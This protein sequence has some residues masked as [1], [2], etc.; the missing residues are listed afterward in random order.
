MSYA[1]RRWIS[2]F[3]VAFICLTWLPYLFAFAMTPPRMSYMW[4]LGNPDDQNVHLMWARQ[5]ADGA[6]TFKDLYTTEKHS[7]KFFHL[8]MLLLGLLHAVTE[9]PLH[10][11]YQVARTVAIALF[12]VGAYWLAIYHFD[13]VP[14]RRSFI[15]F[16]GFS[17]GFGWLAWLLRDW[18]GCDVPSFADVSKGLVMPEAITFL[19]MLV[20]P[21]TAVGV[22]LQACLMASIASFIIN[23]RWR[24]VLLASLISLILGNAHSYAALTVFIVILIWYP[25]NILWTM[26]LQRSQSLSSL[27][28]ESC[29][30]ISLESKI[31][32][33]HLA[34]VTAVCLCSLIGM[35]PQVFAFR[36]DIAFREKA[37][38]QTLTPPPMILLGTYGLLVPLS[39]IG[40]ALGIRNKWRMLAMPLAWVIG[41][42]IAI[43]LP[44][45][46][47]RKLIEGFHIP[48][49]MLA[50]YA[51]AEAPLKSRWRIS[52]KAVYGAV[53]VLTLLM[54]PS[55]GAYIG[56]N[57]YWLL[58]N[59][60]LAERL[61]QPPYYLTQNQLRLIS[62][63]RENALQDDAIIC[64]PMLGNYIPPI[65]GRT[66][67]IG[68]WA[69]TLH[70]TKK[71][72]TLV[73][74]Y[75]WANAPS[76]LAMWLTLT[77][78]HNVRFVLLTDFERAI[79]GGKTALPPFC[80]LVFKAGDD[81]AY[82]IDLTALAKLAVELD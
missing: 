50:A 22:A 45:S 25:L 26:L 54:F 42:L 9:L 76:Q 75:R 71:L 41:T 23:G 39:I 66:V 78:V 81:E 12:F 34:A 44:V 33:S 27:D 19:T 1:E 16:L 67:F 8:P 57:T 4:L 13:H 56:L 31:A 17:S 82:R 51:A 49:C 15:L 43:H 69:E 77:R 74:C 53:C 28:R 20:A 70:F 79:S 60:M 55:N 58:N 14:S 73:T 10:L 7:G 40:V 29:K 36:A 37:L 48:L 47:Q 59:N 46:F 64:S 62:W 30:R 21:L 24:S 80:K 68:H 61:L 6:L 63:L 11:L 65:S 32:L 72:R 5:A 38:T 2:Y 3:M 52:T 18:L 35:L